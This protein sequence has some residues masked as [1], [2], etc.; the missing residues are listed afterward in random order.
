MRFCAIYHNTH[1]TSVA[2]FQCPKRSLSV[3]IRWKWHAAWTSLWIVSDVLRLVQQYLIVV[4]LVL[5]RAGNAIPR[6]KWRYLQSLT[7]NAGKSAGDLS[8]HATILVTNR[9]TTEKIVVP[10]SLPLRSAVNIHSASYFAT[11]HVLHASNGAHGLAT[12]KGPALCPVP[13]P[14][15]SYHAIN[16]VPR[17]FPAVTSVLDFVVKRVPKSTAINVPTSRILELTSLK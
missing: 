2:M 1:L 9:A 7:K 17:N 12:T 16:A 15:T 14:V 10:V 4:T 5:V 8:E 13:L 6:T 3:V 11:R